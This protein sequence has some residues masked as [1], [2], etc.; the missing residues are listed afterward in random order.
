[1]VDD[2]SERRS[3]FEALYDAYANRV[4]AYALR[5]TSAATAEDIV[6]DTFAVAWRRMECLPADPLPWLLG[7]ARRLLAN[8]RRGARRR[9]RLV[10]RLRGEPLPASSDGGGAAVPDVLAALRQLRRRD[11]EALMLVAWDGLTPTQAAKVLSCSP[12]AFRLRLMRAR[13]RL[14]AALDGE[15][16]ASAARRD[17]RIDDRALAPK[18][19]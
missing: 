5:R 19:P 1:V 12:V 9:G 18:E 3:A 2:R 8:E 7:T 14:R 13:R 6:A 11:A 16:G 15:L 4:L 10:E 17:A